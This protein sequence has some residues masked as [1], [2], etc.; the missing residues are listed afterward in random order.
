MT[1]R[2]QIRVILADDHAMVREALSRILADSGGITVEGQASDGHEA[3]RLAAR[4]RPDVV[5]LDYTMPAL[6]GPTTLDALLR[7]NPE[8]K[9]LILTVHESIHY[10]MK[11][12]E[13]GAH[14]YVVKSA[15]VQELVDAIKAVHAGEIY[16]S[17]KISQKVLQRLRQP[18]RDRAG[19]DSLSPR[20]FDLLRVLG[21]GM[22]LTQ[23]AEHLKVGTSTAS[24]YRARLMEKLRLNTTAEIIRFALEND[25]VG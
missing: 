6:D 20:E 16:I 7:Q 17:H 12:L 13:A 4:T 25:I 19:L 23:A 21:A 1:E 18:K 9:I 11:V 24:T 8:V 15:A 2:K 5:V 10:A 22:S 3:V 14:G